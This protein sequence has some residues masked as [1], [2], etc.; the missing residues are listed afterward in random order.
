VAAAV[1]VA[2]RGRVALVD[3]QQCSRLCRAAQW[4]SC[5]VLLA[6]LLPLLLLV[7]RAMVQLRCCLGG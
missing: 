3:Q 7:V 4:L 1:R 6:V 5:W 2:V